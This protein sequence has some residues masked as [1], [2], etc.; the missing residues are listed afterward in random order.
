MSYSALVELRQLE[1]L[2]AAAAESEAD[3]F[4]GGRLMLAGFEQRRVRLLTEHLDAHLAPAGELLDLGLTR[5]ATYGTGGEIGLLA[6]ILAPLQEGL[7]AIAQSLTG[8]PTARG[9][10]PGTIQDAVALRVAF[11]LPGSLNLRLVPAVPESQQPLFAGNH[12]LLELSLEHL[13]TLVTRASESPEAALDAISIA[14]PRAASHL[15]AL[16]KTLVEGQTNLDVRWRSHRAKYDMA[17]TARVAGTLREVLEAV[18]DET[19]TRKFTGRLVGGNLIRRTFDLELEQPEG[20]VITGK[21]T[22]DVLGDLE[23]L[24]GGICT[25]TVEVRES[26]LHSGETREQF[27]LVALVE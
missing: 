15:H 17:L 19:R 24:F 11:A 23:V 18:T 4:V 3:A 27:T 10:I 22:E 6:R 14:G 26:S 16:S 7:S 8:R 20:T 9:Q 25:A 13:V 1:D 21:A 2:I 5:P 12:T